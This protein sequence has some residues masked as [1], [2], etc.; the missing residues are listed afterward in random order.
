VIAWVCA[1]ELRDYTITQRQ[2]TPAI[3]S[4]RA[5]RYRAPVPIQVRPVTD[6]ELPRWYEAASTAFFIWPSGDPEAVAA[7]RRPHIQLD[8]TIGAF[9]D[10]TIVG[11][12]RSFPT[13]LTMP[14][15]A[16]LPV[17]GITAVTVR[18]T[19]RR[20]GILSQMVAED[21]RATVERDEAASILIAAEWPIY[22]RFGYG[23]A[24]SHAAWAIRARAARF[25]A[26]PTGSVEIMRSSEAKPVITDIYR[27]Y[28]AGQPGEIARLD[29]WWDMD[30]GLVEVPGRKKWSGIVAVHR[31]EDGT[32]DAYARYHGEEK[33][34]EGIPDNILE[35][36]A[37]HGVSVEAE[38]EMW[39][40]L[41][42]VDLVATIK[43]NTR[44]V[45]EPLPWVLQDARAARIKEVGEFYWIRIFDVARWLS[46]RSY[47]RSD[48][49]VIE[50]ADRLADGDGPAAGRY[51]LETGPDGASCARTVEDADLTLPVGAL[52]AVSLGGTRLVE[53]IR[54]TGAEEHKAGAIARADRLFKTLEEPYGSTWF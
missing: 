46:N 23:P 43:A 32:A 11:T 37:M 34:D 4:R 36:D 40:F 6:A 12:Y 53:A 48:T 20:R 9:E 1:V 33:W 22:G 28:Q 13:Q 30:L 3:A 25:R 15:L 38:I 26:E 31:A 29:N 50:V 35:L 41:T 10:A 45:R 18:P 51:R 19:H 44:R 24:S 14:G 2:T 8:R 54:Q 27:R 17:G 5:R 49:L 21:I 52:G 16:Q 47:D 42:R 39:Q 7:A